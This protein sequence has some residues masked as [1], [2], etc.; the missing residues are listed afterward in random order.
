LV[1][2][3]SGLV[4]EVGL[5]DCSILR[6]KSCQIMSNGFGSSSN[7]TRASKGSFGA[8]LSIGPS[9]FEFRNK[10]NAFDLCE[11]ADFQ[12]TEILVFIWSFHLT[13]LG[14]FAKP[15][16]DNSLTIFCRLFSVLQLL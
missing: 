11:G 13:C 1:C 7:F 12:K 8:T 15:F 5:S 3:R 6:K 2:A 4:P 9:G 14:G 10:V 16:W